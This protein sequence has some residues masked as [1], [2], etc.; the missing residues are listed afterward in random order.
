MNATDR[1]RFDGLFE[2][3]LAQLGQSIHDL[4]ERVP[5]IID[6]EPPADLCHDMDARPDELC[7]LHTGIPLT[8]R[9]VEDHGVLEDTVHLFRLG[10]I[11]MAGGWSCTGHDEHGRPV[12][13]DEAVRDEIRITLL[14]ELGHHMGLDE[15]DLERLGYA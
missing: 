13:G 15:D 2:E 12:G 3:V 8:E 5:V 14:H 7:G 4:I 9:S 11:A 10:I 6:D 1:D